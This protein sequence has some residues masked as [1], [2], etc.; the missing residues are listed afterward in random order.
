MLETMDDVVPS[1]PSALRA[2]MNLHTRVVLRLV[3]PEP[4]TP[5]SRR[6]A[7]VCDVVAAILLSNADAAD[8]IVSDIQLAQRCLHEVRVHSQL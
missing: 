4:F 6:L 2:L 8:G 3:A 5:L 1:L 7:N